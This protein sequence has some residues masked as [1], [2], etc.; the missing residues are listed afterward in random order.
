MEVTLNTTNRI[1]MNF[2]KYIEKENRESLKR[3]KE[4]SKAVEKHHKDFV[5]ACG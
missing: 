3:L 5:R 2:I 1:K 4:N